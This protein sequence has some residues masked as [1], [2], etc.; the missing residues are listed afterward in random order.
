MPFNVALDSYGYSLFM[1][2]HGRINWKKVLFPPVM[3]GY[4]GGIT[5]GLFGVN[6]SGFL[7]DAVKGLGACMSPAS[8]LSAGIVLGTFG[9]KKL[10]SGARPYLYGLIRLAGIPLLFGVPLFLL[11][12]RGV[13]LALPLAAISMPVGLNTVVFPE[14]FGLDASDNAKLCFVSFIMSILT[15]PVVFAVASAVAGL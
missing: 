4:Y 14:S 10:V 6:L 8:M 5:L 7:G 11:G 9:L 13:Y 12:A 1:E 2:N 15:L 3:L